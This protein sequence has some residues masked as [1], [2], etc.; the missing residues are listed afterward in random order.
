[1]KKIVIDCLGGDNPQ[2][3]LVKGVLNC[4]DLPVDFVLVGEADKLKPLLEK[5]GADMNRFEFLD[6]NHTVTNQQDPSVVVKGEEDSSVVLAMK[7]AKQD[8]AIGYIGVGSTGAVLLSSIF[9][10]GLLPGIKFPA[11]GCFIFDYRFNPICLLD[12]GANINMNPSLALSFA[13]IGSLIAK[14]R[15]QSDSPRIGL[16]NVGKEE[17][18]GTQFCKEAY[19]LLKDSGLNFVGNIEGHDILLG[20][21]DVVLTDGFTGNVVLKAIESCAMICKGIALQNGN[22]ESAETI[23]SMFNYTA[24]GSSIVF[25]ASKI[26]LKPHGSANAQTIDTAIHMVYDLDKNRMIQNLQEGLGKK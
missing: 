7:R 13:E 10:L 14:A 20:K 18:K 5:Q 16:L 23:N 1:M 8:D 24:L 25:G 19:A 9:R 22:Q 15:I 11:L 3:E 17:G 12:C 2:E 21:A 6:A 26:V 4:L